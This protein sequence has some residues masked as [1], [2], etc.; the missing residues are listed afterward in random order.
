MSGFRTRRGH[1]SVVLEV[2]LTTAALEPTSDSSV[3]AKRRS[4]ATTWSRSVQ[5]LLRVL[6]PSRGVATTG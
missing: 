2:S 3:G 6:P 1:D 4:E 5:R